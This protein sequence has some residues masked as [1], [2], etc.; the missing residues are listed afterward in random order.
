[1][2]STR[3][4]YVDGTKSEQLIIYLNDPTQVQSV[5]VDVS[6]CNQRNG[7]WAQFCISTGFLFFFA[8]AISCANGPQQ[9]GRESKKEL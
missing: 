7:S 4:P 6:F 3:R 2:E 8:F 1:M 5:V 9:N